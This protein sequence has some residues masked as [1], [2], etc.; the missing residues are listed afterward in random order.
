MIEKNICFRICKLGFVTN[1]VL[2]VTSKG[3][4]INVKKKDRI[5]LFVVALITG[6][7][8]YLIN[9]TTTKPYM[10]GG[11]GNFGLLFII[12]TVPLYVYMSFFLYKSFNSFFGKYPKNKIAIYILISLLLL[13]VLI[14]GEYHYVQTKLVELNKHNYANQ[15]RGSL[16]LLGPFTNNWY[17]NGYTYFFLPLLAVIRSGV[18]H[19]FL[20]GKLN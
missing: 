3:R 18:Q 14:I 4:W 11:N 6:S 8:F 9:I 5:I 15:R 17:F 19:V 13:V 10:T 12:F 1:I 20:K 2:L 7:L 16:T